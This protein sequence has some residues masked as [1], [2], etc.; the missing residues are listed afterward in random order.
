MIFRNTSTLAFLALGVIVGLISASMVNSA[1]ALR[2]LVCSGGDLNGKILDGLKAGAEKLKSNLAGQLG[3]IQSNL[4]EQLG[5]I[6]SHLAEQL[7]PIQDQ[8]GPVLCQI[9]PSDPRC[10]PTSPG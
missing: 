7:G 5:P 3:P 8:L 2:C 10:G 1:A 9:Q 6:Q 4:A